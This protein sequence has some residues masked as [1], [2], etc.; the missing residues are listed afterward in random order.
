MDFLTKLNRWSEMIIASSSLVNHIN[1]IQSSL[2]VSIVIYKKLLSV[3]C[4]IFLNN[5]NKN[6]NSFNKKSNINFEEITLNQI[7]EFIW[8]MFITFKSIS[9]FFK[10]FFT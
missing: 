4:L 1:Y 8:I 7:F 3:F 6:L 9:S 10:Y 5:S 2:A